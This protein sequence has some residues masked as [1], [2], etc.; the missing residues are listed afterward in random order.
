M[1]VTQRLLLLVGVLVS[2][3]LTPRLSV[4]TDG[5]EGYC[6]VCNGCAADASRQCISVVA[7]GFEATDCMN[8]CATQSCQ[9]LEV[10]EGNCNFHADACTASP[11]P[12]ASRP[13]LF[14]LGALLVGGG[15]Y[16]ARR[17]NSL[18]R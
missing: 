4:A 9:F 5:A 15:V 6:C 11:A 10:L 1:T 17:R 2:L 18:T 3:S 8:R 12:A 14:A 13:V 16:L 7:P